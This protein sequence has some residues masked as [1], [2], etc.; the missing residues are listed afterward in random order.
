MSDFLLEQ[1]LS[2]VITKANHYIA[3]E[4]L[5][6]LDIANFRHDTMYQQFC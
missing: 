6:Y 5:F 2:F 1:I 3:C 4:K